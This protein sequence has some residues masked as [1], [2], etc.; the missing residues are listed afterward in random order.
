MKNLLLLVALTYL[1]TACGNKIIQ[2]PIKELGKG[3][4]NVITIAGDLSKDAFNTTVKAGSD[5]NET[6]KKGLTDSKRELDKGLTGAKQSAYSIAHDSISDVGNSAENIGQFPRALANDLLGTNEDTDEDLKDLKKTVDALRAEMRDSFN[7][8]SNDIGNLA[9]ELRGVDT[10]LAAAIS[11]AIDAA[12]AELAV[13][14]VKIDRN[15][16]RIRR[17]LR[18]IRGLNREVRY[19]S[20]ELYSLEVVCT[21][22]AILDIGRWQFINVVTACELQNS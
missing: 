8:V 13:E 3:T 2:D 7:D 21:E 15:Q 19:I 4:L 5:I 17:A 1:V 10:D 9:Y 6:T 11:D 18:R 16:D 12:H 22:E 20:Y 14:I